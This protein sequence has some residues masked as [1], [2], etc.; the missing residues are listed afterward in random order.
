MDNANS[1]PAIV[2]PEIPTDFESKAGTSK[3]ELAAAILALVR[4]SKITGIQPDQPSPYDLAALTSQVEGHE[5][6]I[7][8]LE[9]RKI[10][11]VSLNGVNNGLV[12]VPFQDIGTTDY[13]VDL[14]YVTPNVNFDPIQWS[15]IEGSKLSNQVQLRLDG[16]SGTFQIEVTIESMAGIAE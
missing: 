15:I 8:K 3:T 12:V 1:Q 9:S 5:T 2:T 13:K 14:A 6:R 10:R 11:R 7:V 4:T 16:R